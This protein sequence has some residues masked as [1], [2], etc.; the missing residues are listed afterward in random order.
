MQVSWLI[1]KK[2]DGEEL[3]AEEIAFLVRGYTAGEIPDYQMSALAMAIYFQDMTFPEIR[4][5]TEEMMN[6]GDLVDTSKI[7][8]PKL[9]KHSTGGIGDKVS[10][11]LAPLAACFDLAVPM[12]SGRGLGVT[13]GTLD[14]LEA[15]PGYRCDLSE[16]EF[17]KV[18]NECGCSIT[19]QTKSLAPADK[20]LY[21]LRDVTGTVPSIPL[22]TSS[23][24]SK[25]LA[26]GI[27]GL[28]L[29]VKFG[30]GA[31][32]REQDQAKRLA[33]TMTEVGKLMGRNVSALLTDMN[34]PLG[35][36]VGNACEVEEAIQTL[37]GQR[38]NGRFTSLCLELVS[39]MLY[40]SNDGKPASHYLP[41]VKEC[42]ESGRAFERFQHMAK[43]LYRDLL[44]L[45]V[46]AQEQR[47]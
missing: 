36:S 17:I 35:E 11:V 16:D 47:Q 42:L 38:M 30:R 12:I 43:L 1:E 31:F 20:K 23:I 32:M 26:A 40:L 22:I 18:V 44:K 19:G 4:V 37:Q 9:D 15:I 45:L 6:S 34:V 5:L 29:D 27:D 28:V 39:E 33:K 7:S 46:I 21:A 41:K 3:S 25:K 8:K 10:L 14:K 2:R 13:G 24:M